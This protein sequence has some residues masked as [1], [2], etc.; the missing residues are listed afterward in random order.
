MIIKYIL[1]AIVVIAALPVVIG[2]V[3]AILT[4]IIG[5]VLLTAAFVGEK[6]LD[7]FTQLFGG[8]DNEIN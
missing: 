7:F 4:E 3:A 1:F 6:T 5:Y 8:E 2:V